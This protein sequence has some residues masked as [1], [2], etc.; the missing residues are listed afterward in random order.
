VSILLLGTEQDPPIRRV[1]DALRRLGVAIHLGPWSA[2]VGPQQLHRWQVEI[3]AVLVRP[4]GV[5]AGIDAAGEYALQCWLDL[6]P[7][8]VLNRPSAAAFCSSKPAQLKLLQHLGWEVPPTLITNSEAAAL[9]FHR[10][11]GDVIVK[12]ISSTRNRVRQFEGKRDPRL[13]F[14]RWCPTQFQKRIVGVDHRVHVVGDRIFCCRIESDDVDYRWPGFDELM[15]LRV[16]ETLPKAQ[17]DLCRQTCKELGLGLA[18]IDL[19]RTSDDRWVIFEVNAMPGFTVFESNNDPLI[20]VA[21]AE[22]LTQACPPSATRD[23]A[24]SRPR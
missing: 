2:G 22:L 9:D 7:A 16:Q 15:P 21:V 17:A 10:R 11:Y 13:H 5:E 3:T 18:G 12:A 20:S 1:A 6:T 19:R 8:L 4:T 24:T 14:L 23:S